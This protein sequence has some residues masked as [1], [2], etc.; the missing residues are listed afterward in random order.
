MGGSTYL[1][2]AT[3]GRN[4]QRALVKGRWG[5]GDGERYEVGTWF[6]PLSRVLE[7]KGAR[8]KTAIGFFRVASRPQQGDSVQG[9][10]AR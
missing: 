6:F 9:T 5:I 2:W 8:P 10:R 3:V 1:R 4:V 7:K